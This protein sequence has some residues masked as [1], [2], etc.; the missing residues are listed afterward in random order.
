MGFIPNMKVL[1]ISQNNY[2]QRTN[3]KAYTAKKI[4]ADFCH[5]SC[6]NHGTAMGAN[7]KIIAD[8]ICASYWKMSNE[9]RSTLLIKTPIV[10]WVVNSK[11]PEIQ[12]LN[13]LA[14]TYIDAIS[15]ETDPVKIEQLEKTLTDIN[16]TIKLIMGETESFLAVTNPALKDK[17]Y[18]EVAANATNICMFKDHGKTNL[19]TIYDGIKD[20]NGVTVNRPNPCLIIGSKTTPCPWHNPEKYPELCRQTKAMLELNGFE[21]LPMEIVQKYIAVQY[22][23]NEVFMEKIWKPFIETLKP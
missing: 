3:F 12:T 16:D 21:G 11:N 22:N 5:G 20:E 4:C 19:C 23:L 8:K 7:L 13:K 17:T 6:C 9:L 10:K 18:E 2:Y 15:K 14:N 1:Q